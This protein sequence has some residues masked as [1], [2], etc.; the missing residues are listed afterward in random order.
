MQI[1]TP[2]Y[3]VDETLLIQN[4]EILQDVMKKTG[5]KIL[6]AQK[7]F[8]MFSLYPLIRRYLCGTTA[9]GL[10][11]AR[12]GAQKFGGETHVFSPAYTEGEFDEIASI[13]GHVVFNSLRQLRQ[14]KE[15]ALQKGVSVG[16]RVNPM[17]STQD[18]AIYDP[19]AIGS[20]LGMPK[21]QVDQNG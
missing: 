14:F 1:Q 20:R 6:L 21:A 11:E 13:C 2:Y 7:A 16:V 9:S 4:L 17:C 19:C 5:C 3:Y 15:K 12:L 18:H 8:G 10:Y